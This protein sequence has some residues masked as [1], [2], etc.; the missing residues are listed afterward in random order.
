MEKVITDNAPRAGG[1]YTQA[2]AHGDFIF[3]SSQ[4]PRPHPSFGYHLTKL[5]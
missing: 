3:I 5:L 2:I 1:H 4:L